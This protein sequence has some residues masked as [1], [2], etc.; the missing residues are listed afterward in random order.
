MALTP[1]KFCEPGIILEAVLAKA[2][3]D[4]LEALDQTYNYFKNTHNEVYTK[5]LKQFISSKVNSIMQLQI[6]RQ[7]TKA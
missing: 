5:H 6:E 3:S 2:E 7:R 4:Q 1:P